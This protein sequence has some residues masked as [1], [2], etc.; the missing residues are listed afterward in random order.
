MSMGSVW[1]EGTWAATA[2]RAVSWASLYLGPIGRVWRKGTWADG[3]WAEGAWANPPF[4]ALIPIATR[5]ASSGAP[6]AL[7]VTS[8]QHGVLNVE[9]SS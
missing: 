5:S 4:I 6:S 7:S 9:S 1:A 3:I 8:G 2:W